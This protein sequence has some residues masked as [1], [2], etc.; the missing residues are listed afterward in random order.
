MSIQIKRILLGAI[1]FLK[2]VELY[3]ME[4]KETSE[5]E[6]ARNDCLIEIKYSEIFQKDVLFDMKL[7]KNSTDSYSYSPPGKNSIYNYDADIIDDFYKQ[8]C[9]KDFERSRQL[10]EEEKST[11]NTYHGMQKTKN[12]SAIKVN[13]NSRGY[14]TALD[15]GHAFLDSFF[16]S[17]KKKLKEKKDISQHIKDFCKEHFTVKLQEQVE[18]SRKNKDLN[19][20]YPELQKLVAINMQ[21]IMNANGKLLNVGRAV[22]GNVP[23]DENIYDAMKLYQSKLRKSYW[24][25]FFTSTAFFGFAG[26]AWL[27]K[28]LWLGKYFS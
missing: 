27:T 28:K 7:E 14:L 3:G 6:R 24:S 20:N 23:E 8:I 25:G 2:I 1:F 12:S 19:F 15:I 10:N 17:E 16:E 9:S 11:V 4:N 5:Y 18:L 26:F 21:K 13:I 22:E